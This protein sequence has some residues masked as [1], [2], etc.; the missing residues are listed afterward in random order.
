MALN[1]PIDLKGYTYEYWMISSVSGNKLNGTTDVVLSLYK[2]QG[3][4][5]L[6]LDS[7]I[8]QLHVRINDYTL[9]VPDLYTLLKQA[10]TSLDTFEDRDRIPFFADS[11]DA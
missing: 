11:N 8:M 10:E 4:R 1:K 2:N 9:V 3:Q 5:D 6:E 7:H